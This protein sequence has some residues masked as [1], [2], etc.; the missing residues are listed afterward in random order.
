M[1]PDMERIKDT[2]KKNVRNDFSFNV[3]INGAHNEQ[4]W[5]KWFPSF[6]NWWMGG[7]KKIK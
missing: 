5:R 1:V 6:Y 2:I 4:T 3:D 7:S